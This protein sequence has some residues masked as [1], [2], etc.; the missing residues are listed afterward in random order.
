MS[1]LLPVAVI[2]ILLAGGWVAPRLADAPGRES[3][4]AE[5]SLFPTGQLLEAVPDGFRTM[6]ADLAWLQAVQY[7]G[8]HHLSDR[9]YPFAEHLFDVTTRLDPEFRNAYIF[10]GWVLGEEARDMGAA[11]ALLDRGIRNVR[12]DWMIAFQRGFLESMAGDHALGAIQMAHAASMEGAPSYAGRVAAFACAR[13]G[14]RE[15]AIQLW[16][17]MAGD[18][19]PAIR[20]MARDRLQALRPGLKPGRNS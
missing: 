19:D 6:G 7:Y 4:E 9:A 12:D 10:G 15:L 17:A 1:R 20:A 16:Q 14:R 2:A 5:L 13:T 18:P 3:A 8:K 11:R